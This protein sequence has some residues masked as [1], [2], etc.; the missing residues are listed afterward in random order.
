MPDEVSSGGDYPQGSGLEAR[1]SAVETRL[2][3]IESAVDAMRL[4]LA[5]IK[6]KL[7]NMPTTVT[8]F[9]LIVTVFAAAFGL[10]IAVLRFAPPH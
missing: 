8:L 6:G 2:A 3:R 7:S 5:E 9:G 10:S 1:V 4:D